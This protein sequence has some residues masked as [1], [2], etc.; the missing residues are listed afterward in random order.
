MDSLGGLLTKGLGSNFSAVVLNF[1]SFNFN[2][3]VTPI[4]PEPEIKAGG[5]GAVSGPIPDDIKYYNVAITVTLKGKHYGKNY[6]VKQRTADMIIRITNLITKARNSIEI[7]V[8]RIKQA[9]GVVDVQRRG[10]VTVDIKKQVDVKFKTPDK[11]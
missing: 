8:D 1:P 9:F 2:I 7:A 3:T 4:P 6:T 10:D 11:K 5:G